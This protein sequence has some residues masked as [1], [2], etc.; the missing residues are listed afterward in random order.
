MAATCRGGADLS[1]ETCPASAAVRG[2]AIASPARVQSAKSLARAIAT[3]LVRSSDRREEEE[4]AERGT[5]AS[6][7]A[8]LEPCPVPEVEARN[9]PYARFGA[10][11]QSAVRG[12]HPPGRL[13]PEQKEADRAARREPRTARVRAVENV[14]GSACE[15]AEAAEAILTVDGSLRGPPTGAEE[16]CASGRM[17]KGSGRWNGRGAG[18]DLRDIHAAAAR[19]NAGEASRERADVRRIGE[20]GCGCG[21]GQKLRTRQSEVSHNFRPGRS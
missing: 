20:A 12:S 8:R 1:V 19:E 21:N 10:H 2:K 5:R 7:T 18:A 17:A 16:T 9:V 15:R 4:A 13:D 14:R 6:S 3:G 11:W